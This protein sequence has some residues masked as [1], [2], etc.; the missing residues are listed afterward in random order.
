VNALRKQDLWD[1]WSGSAWHLRAAL[2]AVVL[3]LVAIGTLE[4]LFDGSALFGF[5]RGDD[6]FLAHEDGVAPIQVSALRYWTSVA[7]LWGL[8]VSFGFL[9]LSL[10][11]R[12]RRSA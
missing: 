10:L 7:A 12:A 8:Y 4:Q 6:Y 5:T 9:C 3:S 2:V 11:L 1:R